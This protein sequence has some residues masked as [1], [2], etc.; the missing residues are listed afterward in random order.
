MI[1]IKRTLRKYAISQ[2]YLHGDMM[3]MKYKDKS[4]KFEYFDVRSNSWEDAS[5]PCWEEDTEYRIKRSIH[6]SLKLK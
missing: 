2:F 3:L 4:I 6:A 1:N 5:V